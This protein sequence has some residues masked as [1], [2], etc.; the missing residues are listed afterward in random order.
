[1]GSVGGRPVGALVFLKPTLGEERRR[2]STWGGTETKGGQRHKRH[3]WVPYTSGGTEMFFTRAERH[4]AVLLLAISLVIASGL[5][6]SAAQTP[7]SPSGSS[8]T[9]LSPEK[10]FKKVSPSVLVIEALGADGKVATLGSGVVIAREGVV[11]NHHVV[12]RGT[13]IHVRRRTKTW[14]ASL[15]YTDPQRDLVRLDVPGLKSPPV[16]IRPS[17]SLQ[18]GERVYAIGAPKGFELTLSEGLISGVR[19]LEGVQIIQI[20]APISSGSSGGG[21]FDAQGRLIGITTFYVEKGQNLNFA[22]PGEWVS[23]LL[24]ASSRSSTAQHGERNLDQYSDLL[25]EGVMAALADDMERAGSLFRE[26]IRLRPDDPEGWM[27][28]GHWHQGQG[29]YPQAVSA[30]R[31]AIRLKPD[32]A[33]AWSDL[34]GLYSR[35]NQFLEA[36]SAYREVV[37]LKPDNAFNWSSLGLAYEGAD[38]YDQAISAFREAVRLAPKKSIFWKLLGSAFYQ[39]DKFSEAISA[40]REA[41][42]LYREA[43]QPKSSGA[44]VSDEADVWFKLGRVYSDIRQYVQAVSAFR[45]AIRLIPDHSRAWNGLGVAYRLQGQYQQAVKAHREALRLNPKSAEVWQDLG[46]TYHEVRQYPQAISAYEEAIRI[47]PDYSTAWYNLGAAYASQGD[48]SRVMEIYER[49]KTLNPTL[50]K[51]YFDNVVLP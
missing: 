38:Q 22:L 8:L 32:N 20:T 24:T 11:T 23:A 9:S 42:R 6:A 12:E 49:L 46:A 4:G 40:Y 37:R 30:F 5:A 41:I 44:R 19:R 28:L 15:A 25:T 14:A 45:E 50:A 1:M 10:L 27:H 34:G 2:A 29:Q 47:K 39:Q 48:R 35:Q 43:M 13:T 3:A 36:V 51:E 17:N 31:E 18:I 26:A 33:D 7:S 21:L 16:E